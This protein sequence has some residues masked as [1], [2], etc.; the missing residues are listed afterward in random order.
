MWPK[1]DFPDILPPAYKRGSGRPKKLRRRQPDETTSQNRWNRN[2][3]TNQCTVCQDYG[4]NARGCKIAK[5]QAAKAA[6]DTQ[7][8]GSQP[9]GPKKRGKEKGSLTSDV[10]LPTQGS[11]TTAPNKRGR[12]KGQTSKTDKT[13]EPSQKKK[14]TKKGKQVEGAEPTINELIVADPTVK[15]PTSVVLTVD[16][17]GTQLKRV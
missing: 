8:Q 7:R 13:S 17:G 14:K 9:T 10:P 4:H 5:E 11:Q 15:E 2:N 3:T 12:S 16:E 1:T 6:N